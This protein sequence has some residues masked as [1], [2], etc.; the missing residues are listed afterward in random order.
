VGANPNGTIREMALTEKGAANPIP[1]ALGADQKRYF[2]ELE[3]RAQALKGKPGKLILE[4]ENALFNEYVVS[5]I[6]A[7]I[8]AGFKD[9]APS[10][11]KK[12]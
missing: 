12:K 10:P 5:L 7:G 4:I 3:K 11:A 8:R 9:I 1:V 2:T 6:D